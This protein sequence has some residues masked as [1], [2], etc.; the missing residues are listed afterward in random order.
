MTQPIVY[1]VDDDKAVRK[2]ISLL[3]KSTGRQVEAYGSAEEFLDNYDSSRS[4]CL[5]LDV[6]MPGISGLSLQ[7]ILAEKKVSLPVIIVTGHG[8]IKMAVKATKTGAVDFLQKPF[9]DHELINSIDKAISQDSLNRKDLSGHLEFDKRY[10]DLSK[11]EQE[12]MSLLVLGESNKRI[13]FKLGISLKTAEF[14]RKNVMQKMGADSFAQ[15]VT[16][17]ITEKVT[18]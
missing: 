11:R 16:W 9:R 1:V 12:V 17:S 4:G 13:A 10:S 5:V 6:R 14:H 3:V 8:D 18:L 7:E 15:L 2:A